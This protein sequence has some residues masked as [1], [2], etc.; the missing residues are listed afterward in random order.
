MK[1]LLVTPTYFDAASI[2]GGGERYVYELGRALARRADVTLLTFGNSTLA[3]R[4]EGLRIERLKRGVLFRWHP[5]YADPFSARFMRLV[6]GAD[7]VHAFQ[8]HT[9]ST[10]AAI[11]LGRLFGRKTFV[12]DLGGGHRG[13]LSRY[14]PLLRQTDGFL[15]ISEF[16]RR[17]WTLAQEPHPARLDV[18]YGGVDTGRFIPGTAPRSGRALFVG[19][20]MP[21]K[22]IDYLIDAIR[23]P[24]ELDVIGRP[25]HQE[26]FELLKNKAEGK[27]VRFRADIEDAALV[28]AYQQAL[29]TVLPSVH[30]TSLG[31]HATSP[32]LLGLVVLESLACGTPAIVSNV[33]SLPEIVEDGVTGFV[34]PP[35]DPAA[36]ADRIG[37]LRSNPA[38]AQAMGKRGRERVLA[39]FTWD[40]VA[41]RCLSAY[42]RSVVHED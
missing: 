8:M 36:L 14:L 2:V 10:D 24:L 37:Y 17:Q 23:P 28:Q 19:R 30:T 1:I 39:Q 16:S 32:E 34:V 22:G 27:A 40:A 42:S 11:V 4:E 18:I 13:A 3:E 41:D 5:L 33:T 35:N 21:H 15:L 38:L 31:A 6:R 29:V 20:L 7:V 25:Y 12:T 26:Y 9:F